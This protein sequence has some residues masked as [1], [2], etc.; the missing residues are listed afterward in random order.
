MQDSVKIPPYMSIRP[1]SALISTV[2]IFCIAR[3]AHNGP[4]ASHNQ[5][6]ISYRIW[7]RFALLPTFYHSESVDA[8]LLHDSSKF[9]SMMC[10]TSALF[11][12]SFGYNVFRYFWNCL[13][14][15]RSL[16]NTRVIVVVC[17]FI[18]P[19]PLLVEMLLY[20]RCFTWL[21]GYHVCLEHAIHI[22]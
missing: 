3:M 2:R 8:S 21:S 22:P 4:R 12:R 16:G 17:R 20:G 13:S 5:T 15:S 19:Y 1:F 9:F 6:C 18:F 14:S 10:K 7:G 11:I